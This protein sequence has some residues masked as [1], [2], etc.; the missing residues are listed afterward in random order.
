M[1]GSVAGVYRVPMGEESFAV[2]VQRTDTR[3]WYEWRVD[4]GRARQVLGP[5]VPV[6]G[7]LDPI[8]LFAPEA[9]LRHKVSATTGVAP[10]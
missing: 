7:N 10:R 1:K 6:Q 8:A 4:I 2:A 3:H 5:D 9:E